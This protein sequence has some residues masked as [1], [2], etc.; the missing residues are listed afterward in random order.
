LYFS[1][2]IR[3]PFLEN[4]VKSIPFTSNFSGMESGG[5]ASHRALQV[6]VCG[7]G[8]YFPISDLSDNVSI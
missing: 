6:A 3:N 8:G 5:A 2:V 4:V 7:L 1:G